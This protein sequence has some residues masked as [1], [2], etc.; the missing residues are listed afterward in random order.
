MLHNE[1]HSA[2]SPAESRIICAKLLI[3][4]P[5]LSGT[6]VM[7]I[8]CLLQCCPH[9]RIAMTFAAGD[10]HDRGT[11]VGWWEAAARE[12]YEQAGS[13]YKDSSIEDAFGSL[14]SLSGSGQAG[15]GAAV[16]LTLRRVVP[17]AV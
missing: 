11:E 9:T 4:I 13:A 2:F 7:H 3:R 6:S 12:A 5:V 14:D 1:R 15:R 8:I 10:V 16:D 17:A